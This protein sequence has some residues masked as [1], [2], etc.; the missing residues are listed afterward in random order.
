MFCPW[1]G[2]QTGRDAARCPAC[3]KALAHDTT[4]EREIPWTAGPA[5]S[6]EP[7]TPPWAR[8]VREVGTAS[9][10]PGDDQPANGS[11]D[12]GE[13][14]RMVARERGSSTEERPWPQQPPTGDPFGAAPPG[15]GSYRPYGYGPAPPGP[16]PPGQAPYSYGPYA[17]GYQPAPMAGNSYSIAA[18]VCGVVAVFVCWIVLGPVGI[19]LGS[20][21]KNR[22]E[23]LANV[24]IAVAAIGMALGLVLGVLVAMRFQN[25]ST[26]R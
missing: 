25:T 3:G 14:P 4:V 26:L 9:R 15:A 12:A 13:P 5:G 23:K 20:K 24:G 18:I 6:G 11:R 16:P 22:G 7:S 1:C 8:E 17:Y 21:A 10:P 2:A 19:A